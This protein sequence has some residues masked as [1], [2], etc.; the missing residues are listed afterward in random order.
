MRWPSFFT[1]KTLSEPIVPMSTE[2]VQ[3]AALEKS[4]PE[5]VVK[6]SCDCKPL[7]CAPV[8]CVCLP[9]A[10]AP[11][12]WCVPPLCCKGSSRSLVLRSTSETGNEKL[13]AV[14]DPTPLQTSVSGSQ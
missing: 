9:V 7:P 2:I 1:K 10:C 13:T 4:N 5:Q 11:V 6:K 14:A 12:T 8:S 3:L